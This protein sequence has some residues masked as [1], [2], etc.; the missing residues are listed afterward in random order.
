[1]ICIACYI[2]TFYTPFNR[3]SLKRFFFSGLDQSRKTL[4]GDWDS[5]PGSSNR[6][7]DGGTPQRIFSQRFGFV[8]KWVFY[9]EIPQIAKTKSIQI[10][11]TKNLIFRHQFD[12][13]LPYDGL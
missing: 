2:F 3:V 11:D 12:H 9:H 5:D 1:M 4:I 10:G 8:Q 7:R 6:F 13:K